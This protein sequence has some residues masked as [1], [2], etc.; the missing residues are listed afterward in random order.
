MPW[1]SIKLKLQK[2]L[3]FNIYT[4]YSPTNA[5]ANSHIKKDTQNMRMTINLLWNFCMSWIRYWN[6]M[7]SMEILVFVAAHSEDIHPGTS[8]VSLHKSQISIHYLVLWVFL[9]R[10]VD[11]RPMRLRLEIKIEWHTQNA[12]GCPQLLKTLFKIFLL[13]VLVCIS[14]VM[15]TRIPF[16]TQSEC[17]YCNHTVKKRCRQYV[18]PAYRK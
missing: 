9:P 18:Q 7:D 6:N 17:I 11:R 12:I 4:L 8:W 15:S 3:R 1:W 14:S 13:S 10:F 5:Q 16:W 2:V